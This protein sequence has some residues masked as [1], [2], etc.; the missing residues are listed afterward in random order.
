MQEDRL[1]L[2]QQLL[3]S[4]KRARSLALDKEALEAVSMLAVLWDLTLYLD[5]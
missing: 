2:Q 1:L 5:L 3:Q 4:E